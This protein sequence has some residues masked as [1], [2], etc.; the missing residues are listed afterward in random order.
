MGAAAGGVQLFAGGHK[1]G[2]HG[3]GVGFAAG[4]YAYAALGGFGE[5]A[6]FFCVGEVRFGLPGF[7]VGAETEVFVDFVGVDELVGVHAVGGV[8]DVFE[9][10][11]GSHEVFAEHF[12]VEG[13]AGLAVTVFSG[14]RAAVSEGDVGGAVHELAEGEDAFGGFEVEVD[15]H[16]DAALA[17]VSVHRAGVVELGHENANGA[18]VAAELCG[19]D[20]GVFPALPSG[21]G[22]SVWVGDEG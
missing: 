4:S 3:G 8:E 12:G 2:A 10:A 1:A 9:L 11:E 19:V 16:V 6:V 7:I 15:A 14:E 20:G 21:S 13:G 18:Q 17:E 22:F 5:G